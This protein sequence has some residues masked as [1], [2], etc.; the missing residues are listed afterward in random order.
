[1][2]LPYCILLHPPAKSLRDPSKPYE[3]LASAFAPVEPPVPVPPHLPLK[4]LD[5][6][7]P[8][9]EAELDV[10]V[11]SIKQAIRQGV[12][13]RLN[14]AGS[15]GSYFAK[16]PEGKTRGIFK[17]KSEEPYGSLNPK[18]S[19]WF[20]RNL[21]A[22]FFGFGRAC[23]LPNFS[24][25]SEAGA[26][27]LDTRL[28]LY[29]VP[30]TTLATL[31]SPAFFYDWID[32]R[33]Y[34]QKKKP[35]PGKIGSLQ[36]F[37]DGYKDASEFLKMHPWPGRA[38]R[39]TLGLDGRPSNKGRRRKR[40]SWTR[41]CRLLCGT[42][43]IDDDESDGEDSQYAEDDSEM[44]ENGRAGREFVWTRELMEDFRLE[45]VSGGKFVVHR[46]FGPD[47][48]SHTMLSSQLTYRRS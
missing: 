30:P 12:H 19:K 16:N 7:A 28:N 38:A 33:A 24:Y 27:M 15:S 8:L 36:L 23:L 42:A 22:P 11:E 20:H 10:V 18:W 5:H 14:K 13:P 1:M 45:L 44:M 47:Q 40:G 34:K 26:S 29:I 46:L 35:L 43:G 48:T 31:S 21:L 37:L 2:A 4:T 32:R 6:K 41:K 17:P 3:I 25:L 9:T 39:D